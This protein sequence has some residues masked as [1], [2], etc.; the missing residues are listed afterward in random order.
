MMQ[1]KHSISIRANFWADNTFTFCALFAKSQSEPQLPHS[2]L[3]PWGQTKM[4]ES[5]AAVAESA[6]CFQPLLI[7]W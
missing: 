5:L 4:N 7:S 6:T 2:V 3:A 1:I